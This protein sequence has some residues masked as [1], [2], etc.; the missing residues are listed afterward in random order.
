MRLKGAHALVGVSG[1]FH[2]FC[3]SHFEPHYYAE[4]HNRG[5]LIRI[6]NLS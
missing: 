4:Y 1:P 5:E 6:L 3:I 2:G